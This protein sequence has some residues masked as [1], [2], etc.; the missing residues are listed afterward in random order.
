M[1]GYQYIFRGT[2]SA[3]FHPDP[4]DRMISFLPVPGELPWIVCPLPY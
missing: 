4:T 2:V 3:L 1:L